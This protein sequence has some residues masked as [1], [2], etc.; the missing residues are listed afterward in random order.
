[1]DEHTRARLSRLADAYRAAQLAADDA[2]EARD[3]AI[4]DAEQDGNPHGVIARA[5]SIGRPTVHHICTR[6]AT[7]RS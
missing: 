7:E 2:R 1:M 4:Y 5:C 3:A 6:V